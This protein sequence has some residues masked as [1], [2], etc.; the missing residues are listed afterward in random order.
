MVH[1]TITNFNFMAHRV[2]LSDI[3]V[4]QRFRVHKLK[5][6]GKLNLLKITN[7]FALEISVPTQTNTRFLLIF[8]VVQ[9][10]HVS[11]MNGDCALPNTFKRKLISW[12][13][14]ADMFH[15]SLKL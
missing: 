9:E 12:L 11:K 4:R 13:S 6:F 14:E 8:F 2:V 5:K 15:Y 10:S 3:V 1:F 7:R